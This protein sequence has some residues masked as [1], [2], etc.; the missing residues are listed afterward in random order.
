[1]G[2]RPNLSYRLVAARQQELTRDTSKGADKLW[3]DS[4]LYEPKAAASVDAGR[5]ARRRARRLA[6]APV[7]VAVASHWQ[8]SHGD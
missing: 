5:R 8:L 3:N 4:R 2:R 6:P 7:R 1:M